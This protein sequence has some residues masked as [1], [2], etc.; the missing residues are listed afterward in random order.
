MAS[1]AH[2]LSDGLRNRDIHPETSSP[3]PIHDPLDHHPSERGEL[4][5]ASRTHNDD[6]PPSPSAT[7][8]RPSWPPLLREGYGFRPASGVSTPLTS[9]PAERGSPLPDP[10]GLG[11]PA[12]ST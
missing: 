4:E 10:N 11:W 8:L 2:L 3:D 6:Q 1:H 7:S 9:L 5:L 12:K